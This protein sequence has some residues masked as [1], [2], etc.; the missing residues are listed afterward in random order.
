MKRYEIQPDP[1]RLQRYGITLQQLEQAVA[2]ANSN[3]GGQYIA[4]GETVQVVRGM[5]LIG[6][7]EDPMEKAMTMD[8]PL[9]AASY[10]RSE[11]ERRIREIRQ[12]VL[13]SVNNVPIRVGDVVDG[14][15]LTPGDVPGAR[16]VVVG[17]QSRLGRVLI[18]KPLTDAQ[19]RETAGP[20]RPPPLAGRKRRRARH[21]PAAQGRGVAPGTPRRRSPG[22]RIEQ[23]PRPDAARRQN[24]SLLRPQPPG[25]HHHG[26][27]PGKHAHGHGPGV[28]GAAR[29]SGQP[30]QFH[31][32]GDQCPA[33]RSGGLLGLV[34][35]RRVGQPV[36]DRGRGLRHPGGIVRVHGG[37]HLPLPV[38]GPACGT[39]VEGSDPARRE[40]NRAE[41]VLLHGDHGLRVPAA[42][43]DGR[44]RRPDLQTDGQH[45]RFR[46]GRRWCWPSACPRC[47][48]RCCCET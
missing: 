39:A 24:R 5:G 32:R 18:S 43:H 47:C 8:D 36:V 31:H 13:A 35:A 37:E 10:L 44:S 28:P 7:G 3:V 6:L 41:P 34:P 19:G 11:E 9:A 48:A 30:P 14:G 46:L 33:G 42:V 2:N 27:G 12:I 22:R 40:R 21:R 16:G 38:A 4:Q 23:H 17:H 1:A 29:F 26:N 15:P 25:Q 20:G 45:V